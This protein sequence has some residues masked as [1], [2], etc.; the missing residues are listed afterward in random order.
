MTETKPDDP[1]DH[2]AEG[3]GEI[4]VVAFREARLEYK[5][6]EDSGT[7]AAP[8][9]MPAYSDFVRD[10]VAAALKDKLRGMVEAG[11]D[12]RSA[13][14]AILDKDTRQFPVVPS[15]TRWDAALADAAG[16]GTT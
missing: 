10:A 5:R 14:R 6:I 11:A 15:M 16:E 3:M 8:V 1:L 2:I 4:A 12:M 13:L 7:S 9:V